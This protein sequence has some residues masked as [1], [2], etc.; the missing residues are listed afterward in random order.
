MKGILRAIPAAFL[1]WMVFLCGT[2]AAANI[3]QP[4]MHNIYIAD[5]A[6]MMSESEREKL[7]T[8]GKDLDSKSGAQ[9]VVVTVNSLEGESIE[10]YANTLFRSWG[11]G[12]KAK[13]N[14][15]LLLI[16]KEDRKFRIE[17]GYGLEGAITDGYAGE[18]LDGMKSDFKQ[19]YYDSG[20]LTAY[21]LLAQK[22]YD[23]YGISP[24]EESQQ[25]FESQELSTMEMG[26]LV[27]IL[28]LIVYLSM[29]F[30][31]TR[32]GRAI[33]F[34]GSGSSGSSSGG[35]YGGGRSGGGGASGGW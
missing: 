9:I 18:V 26:I 4:P 10:E 15:V 20:I 29:K 1:L 11:I 34:G 16:A 28:F 23:E 27:G 14:G 25:V 24:S 31:Q 21:S 32:V 35:G 3:P 7:L 33:G 8:I 2:A 22:V 17:V 19:E 12:D 13:D 6:K 30:G 5:Y